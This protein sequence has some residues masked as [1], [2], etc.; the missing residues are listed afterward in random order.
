MSGFDNDIYGYMLTYIVKLGSTKFVE[1]L[2]ESAQKYFELKIHLFKVKF[3]ISFL[4]VTNL[5]HA[6]G[7]IIG[8]VVKN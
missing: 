5:F 2:L 7:A 8:P 1:S 6:I 3:R 4:L